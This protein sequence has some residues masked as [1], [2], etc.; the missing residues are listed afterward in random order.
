M[1]TMFSTSLGFLLQ[2]ARGQH[3]CTGRQRP[4][5][6]PGYDV[7]CRPLVCLCGV[8]TCLPWPRPA[9]TPHAHPDRPQICTARTCCLFTHSPLTHEQTQLTHK[10]LTITP[11]CT[12]MLLLRLHPPSLKDTQHRSHKNLTDRLRI[13]LR[14]L[15]VTL[16]CTARF[17]LRLLIHSSNWFCFSRASCRSLTMPSI[18]SC[19]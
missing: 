14:S 9:S 8:C 11:I 19:V 12:A 6:W 10:S 1:C 15:T 4:K 13:T 18:C 5:P 16:I 17:L 3:L 7:Q 2:E